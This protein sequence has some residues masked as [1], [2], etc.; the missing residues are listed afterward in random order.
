MKSAVIAMNAVLA[1]YEVSAMI[2][3]N[4]VLAV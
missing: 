1:V 2:A 4:A 3:I